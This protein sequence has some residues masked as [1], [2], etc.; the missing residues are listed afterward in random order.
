[1]TSANSAVIARIV[2][3]LTTRFADI[4]PA[5]A[6]AAIRRMDDFSVGVLY[7]MA[8]IAEE[9]AASNMPPTWR[10]CL[11]AC[12]LATYRAIAGPK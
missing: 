8:C 10:S 12:L 4:K 7:G 11:A 9:S 2:G 5:E 6:R 3:A 1:M